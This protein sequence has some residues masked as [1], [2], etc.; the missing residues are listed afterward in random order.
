MLT[1]ECLWFYFKHG[2]PL[3]MQA[4]PMHMTGY[5][6]S[7][8]YVGNLQ[9]PS[10]TPH[11]STHPTEKQDSGPLVADPNPL[12]AFLCTEHPHITR[13]DRVRVCNERVGVLLFSGMCGSVWSPSRRLQIAYVIPR[14]GVIRHILLL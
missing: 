7:R 9:S 2:I 14:P 13:N 11:I 1:Y 3:I 4:S 8:D 10:W 5:A 12:V 6:G